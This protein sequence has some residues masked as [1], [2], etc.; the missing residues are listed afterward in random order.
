MTT[1]WKEEGRVEG[2][3]EEA[4]ALIKRQLSRRLGSLSPEGRIQV[5]QLSLS[6]LEQLG[7]DLLDFHTPGDLTQWLQQNS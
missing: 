2:R 5:R 4:L 1:S 7:E 6:Q 3:Q